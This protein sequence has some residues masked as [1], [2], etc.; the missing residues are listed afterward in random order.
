MTY[1]IDAIPHFF[2]YIVS[3]RSDIV[4]A[5]WGS[6][7]ILGD[8]QEFLRNGV[9]ST[10]RRRRRETLARFQGIVPDEARGMPC[11][12]KTLS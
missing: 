5:P 7:G 2:Y 6:G 3:H 8:G 9:L 11:L 1:R 4:K 12:W 10:A